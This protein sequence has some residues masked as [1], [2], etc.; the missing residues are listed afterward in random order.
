MDEDKRRE[1]LSSLEA[2]EEN[3]VNAL[4]YLKVYQKNIKRE[5]SKKI[6]PKEF[7][8]GDLVLREN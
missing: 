8:V 6:K 5:Y 1:I 4:E 7:Q 2:L 3:R